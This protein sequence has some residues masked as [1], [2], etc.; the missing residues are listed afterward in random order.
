M[1]ER[2]LPYKQL[3]LISAARTAGV[4]ASV[5]F[6]PFIIPFV[7]DLHCCDE[8]DVSFYAGIIASSGGIASF[9]CAIPMGTLSDH[10][11]RKPIMLLS[12][13]APIL[14]L[15]LLGLSKS[16]L[17]AVLSRVLFTSLD[18]SVTASKVM[19]SEMTHGSSQEARARGFSILQMAYAVGFMIG[20]FIGS[21]LVDPVSKYPGIFQ[22]D[23]V[24]TIFLEAYPYFL[25]CFAGAFLS[26]IMLII[27]LFFMEETCIKIKA[28]QEKSSSSTKLLLQASRSYSTFDYIKRQS[29]NLKPHLPE[30]QSL[31]SIFSL[32]EC[33][34]PEVNN[35]L[36]IYIFLMSQLA[37]LGELA[38]IWM[39]SE[40][41]YGGL[42]FT[43]KECALAFATQG[44]S[45][46]I[47]IVFILTPLT[48][49]F[50]TWR[51]L[52][53][54]A[55]GLVFATT[56]EIGVRYLYH[57]PDLHG[58]TQTPFWVLPAA[59][60][61]IGSWS[62]SLSLS[63]VSTKILINNAAPQHELGKTN[64][65][66]ECLGSATHAAFPALCGAIW[67]GLLK[68]S[69]IPMAWRIPFNWFTPIVMGAIAFYMA[70]RLNSADYIL[71]KHKANPRHNEEQA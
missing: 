15:I 40:R 28:N 21:S 68:L 20:P 45:Q 49:R 50:G 30:K 4:A 63:L 3:I 2:P 34:I 51:V 60:L 35:I 19:V 33:L 71:N 24:L 64:S 29:I 62:M 70:T 32:R 41:K 37:Y 38:P 10:I 22:P 66:A 42:G 58:R 18:S 25:P 14:S 13:C 55:F 16:I 48:K 17:S 9:I 6:L 1:D 36:V 67:S 65:I 12:L 8:K 23:G 11:G 54:G 47:V 56:A 7:R 69:W 61:C 57:L 27:S 59:V 39:S 5:L 26:A 43:P 46:V 52:C 53:I 31:A 44:M